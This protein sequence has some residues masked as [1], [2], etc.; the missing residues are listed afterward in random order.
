MLRG[1]RIKF[2]ALTM[3]AVALVL[4]VV[5]SVICILNYQQNINAVYSAL[6]T[7][8]S[9]VQDSKPQGANQKGFEEG[10]NEEAIEGAVDGERIGA[11]SAP[12]AESDTASEV[13]G[14]KGAGVE[15]TGVVGASNPA[16]PEIGGA[17]EGKDPL[18]PVAVYSIRD[19][20][21]VPV[22]ETN[23]TTASI[24]EEVLAQATEELVSVA[25]GHGKL[26]DVGLFYQKLERNGVTYLAFADG[27][28]ADGWQ[29]LAFS[30]AG[31]GV[32]TLLIFFVISLFFSRWAL[33][34]VEQAWSQQQQFVADASHELKTPLTVILANTSI[35]LS[36]PES[37]ITEQSQW[38]ESTQLEAHRM[39]KL[40]NDMLLLARSDAQRAN[41]HTSSQNV[42]GKNSGGTLTSN[43]KAIDF[44]YVV[45]GQL[46][47]FESVAFE[48]NI[49][50]KQDVAEEVMVCGYQDQ[51]ERLV[52]ILLDNAC[53]YAPEKSA[54][55]V[56][57][58]VSEKKVQLLVNNQGNPIDEADLPHLFDRFYRADK[59]RVRTGG[60][61]LGLAIA[62][63]I[64]EVMGGSITAQSSEAAGTT[65]IVVLPAFS[66]S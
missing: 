45:E 58:F 41:D 47:Q 18:I 30:L 29:F 40:V 62:K 20:S 66:R 50:I 34:P 52:S 27:S 24:A 7:A 43:A 63:D 35:L 13:T 22:V 10:A 39:Q 15:G 38:V 1:L 60:F 56:T 17:R 64:V 11:L 51:L 2:V 3:T 44:S 59:A 4:A 31:V 61:G 46:L 5:F 21:T 25:D 26:D 65:F 16:P 48:K 19:G 54:I 37:K 8:L 32:V 9:F 6:D 28:A 53:K 42:L 14:G 55:T 49:D 23:S 36:H 12:A 33:R 57:L